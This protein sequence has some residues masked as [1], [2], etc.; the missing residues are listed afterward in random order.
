[1]P[2]ELITYHGRLEWRTA[3]ADNNVVR[4]IRAS[5][6]PFGQSSRLD[7]LAEYDALQADYD[8]AIRALRLMM[9]R[10]ESGDSIYTE[11]EIQDGYL[12]NALRFTD[13]EEAAGVAVLT[14]HR[15]T[16]ESKWA[17]V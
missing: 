17:C 3:M 2:E 1:M 7:L 13:E 14:A 8:R 6:S 12:G 16:T 11:P 9:A 10:W 15:A 5:D 4:R